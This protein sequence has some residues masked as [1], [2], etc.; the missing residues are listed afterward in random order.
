MMSRIDLT[1]ARQCQDALTQAGLEWHLV[2]D[3]GPVFAQPWQAQAFAMTLALHE[4]GLFTW[5]QW[6]QT[7]SDCIKSARAA[8]DPDTGQTYYY[9][10]L[11]ALEQVALASRTCTESELKIRQLGWEQ[12]AQRTPHGM[13]IELSEA[14]R[15]LPDA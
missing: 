11:N 8:G 5:G 3:E 13:P 7:L 6:A 10:W 2:Q 12:A 9:H 14:E 1:A 4:R 15:H